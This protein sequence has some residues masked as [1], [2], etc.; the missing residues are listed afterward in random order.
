MDRG[1]LVIFDFD[2]SLINEDSDDFVFRLFHPE[3]AKTLDARFEQTKVWPAVFDDMLQVI[4]REKPSVTTEMIWQQLDQIPMQPRMADAIRLAVDQFGADFKVISD[5]NTFYI[6]GVLQHRGLDQHSSGVF[7]N[8]VEF[9][10]LEDG[11]KWI[12]IRPYHAE[13]DDPL[14]CKWC[15]TNMCKGRILDSI[16]KGKQYARVVYVGDG[17]GDFCPASRLT[18]NDIVCA[19]EDNPD[20]AP[21][22]LQKRIDSNAGLVNATV[23]PWSTGDDIYRIFTQLFTASPQ[24]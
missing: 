1:T 12:R 13:N 9:E 16:R 19:R 20:G 23:V 21:Y 7:A 15:P 24:N 10:V 17:I 22:G 18:A 3:L 5:G 14:G 8:P 2:Q 11:R 6:N 4:A